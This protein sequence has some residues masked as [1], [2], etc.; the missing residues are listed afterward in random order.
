M[1]SELPEFAAVDLAFGALV[2]EYLPDNPAVLKRLAERIVPGGRL[3]APLLE[4]E[5]GVPAVLPSPYLQ[6]LEPLGKEY[7]T[8]TA[9]AFVEA[10]VEAGFTLE[11]CSERPLPSGKR[12][13][14]LVLRRG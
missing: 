10:A 1:N 12:F 9:E 5:A 7:R 2:F 6:A 8:I 14:T 13:K 3:I 11:A 4:A